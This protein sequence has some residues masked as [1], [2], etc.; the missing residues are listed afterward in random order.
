MKDSY[1][2]LC[3]MC[4][5]NFRYIDEYYHYMSE[6]T[7]VPSSKSLILTEKYVCEF[8]SELFA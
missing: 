5:Y 1:V 7:D 8:I 4:I 3:L 6:N 2:N